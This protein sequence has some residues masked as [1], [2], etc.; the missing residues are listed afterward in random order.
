MHEEISFAL[1]MGRVAKTDRERIAGEKHILSEQAV[2]LARNI[3]MASEMQEENAGEALG[4]LLDWKREYSVH[5]P[6][7]FGSRAKRK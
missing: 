1:R 6:Y 5:F 2:L 4:H 3:L 7:P